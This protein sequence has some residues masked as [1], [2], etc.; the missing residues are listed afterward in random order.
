ME[1]NRF[2]LDSTWS[3]W[4]SGHW[5]KLLPEF[6]TESATS[7]NSGIQALLQC[8]A[9][10]QRN[11]IDRARAILQRVIAEC[12][13]QL[14]LSVLLSG[15]FNS[16]ARV[17]ALAGQQQKSWACFQQS[18]RLAPLRGD[19][20]FWA[21]VRADNET[22]HLG[23]PPITPLDESA[24]SWHLPEW[25]QAGLAHMPNAA[26]LL[27]A[28][29][30]KAQRSGDFDS[31]IRY[32]Q[33]LAAVDGE[34]MEQAYYDRL[35]QA[36]RQVQRFP[37]GR[38]EEEVLRGG[39]NKYAILKH[40]HKVL[41]PK[42]YLEI[43]V[44]KGESI[45][46][47]SC[48]A[49]G[50]DPMPMITTAL[51]AQVRLIRATSDEFFSD[52]AHDLLKEE[53]GMAFID[54]MHL[55]EYALRDFINVERYAGEHTVV[56]ID[57]ILPCHPA[58]AARDRRTRS[59][60]GDVWKLLATLQQHR[61]DLSLLLLDAFPTGLLCISGLDPTN[62][63]LQDHYEEIVTTWPHDSEVPES[64]LNRKDALSFTDQNVNIFL[65]QLQDKP[66]SS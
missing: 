44:H 2:E 55:F 30:E 9:L 61:P 33:Q 32:W 59:W 63:I 54:G 45:V 18:M 35:E 10:L 51:S 57:D 13:S 36:Y 37:Q 12:S 29:A 19:S 53:I 60:T 8:A 64:I 14:I 48:P 11:E 58:Q 7:D 50:I 22:R 21:R 27:I 43:G 66:S 62:T 20:D 4:V 17:Y 6:S 28:A 31:A 47:A 1:E 42:N 15:A 40:F 56:V 5:D 3:R 25:I 46:F 34:H 41:R 23:L 26:P 52:Y 16:L 38:P 49:I 65:K 39:T 24:A